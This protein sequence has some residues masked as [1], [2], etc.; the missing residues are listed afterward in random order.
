MNG[1]HLGKFIILSDH[2]I[3]LKFYQYFLSA[4]SVVNIDLVFSRIRLKRIRHHYAWHPQ[5]TGRNN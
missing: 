5:E 2:N 4:V 3:I 1:M